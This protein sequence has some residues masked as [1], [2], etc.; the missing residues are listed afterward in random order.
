M[1]LWCIIVYSRKI[2]PRV[3]TSVRLTVCYIFAIKGDIFLFIYLFTLFILFIYDNLFIIIFIFKCIYL[4]FIY[5]FFKI[6]FTFYLFY[7]PD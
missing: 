1:G 4:F 7:L 5:L 6:L 3:G 2:D